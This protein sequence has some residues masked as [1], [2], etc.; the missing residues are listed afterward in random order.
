MVKHGK[1]VPILSTV[2]IKG[3]KYVQ[4]GRNQF[5]RFNNV[6]WDTGA[7]NATSSVTKNTSNNNIT[8]DKNTLYDKGYLIVPGMILLNYIYNYLKDRKIEFSKLEVRFLRPVYVNEEISINIDGNTISI[9]S[10]NKIV[11]K[12]VFK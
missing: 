4:I 11:I 8:G 6:D 10:I 5:I 12:G 7:D 1:V 9:I 2:T 3:K